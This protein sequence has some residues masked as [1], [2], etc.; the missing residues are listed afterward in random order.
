MFI[1]DDDDAVG[2]AMA[3]VLR[4]SGFDAQHFNSASAFLP[5]RTDDRPACVLLDFRMPDVNGLDSRR[6]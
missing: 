1:V 6:P 3:R 4:A 2:T 5:L